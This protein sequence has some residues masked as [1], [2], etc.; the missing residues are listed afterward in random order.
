MD[1]QLITA[2][3]GKRQREEE[4]ARMREIERRR[5]IARQRKRRRQIM[6]RRMILAGIALVLLLIG[7][8]AGIV[9]EKGKLEEK[10]SS[11]G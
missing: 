2:E 10:E 5:R 1:Y 6:R 3:A 4:E 7:I 11:G 8:I 9:V